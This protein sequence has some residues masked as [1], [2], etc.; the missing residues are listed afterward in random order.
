MVGGDWE[1]GNCK[2]EEEEGGKGEKDLKIRK[3]NKVLSERMILMD[4]MAENNP[5]D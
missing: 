3:R 4:K 1:A 2:E 5:D